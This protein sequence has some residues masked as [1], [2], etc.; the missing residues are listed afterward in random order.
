MN[1][2][3]PKSNSV[4]FFKS[5][6]RHHLGSRHQHRSPSWQE[7]TPRPRV[8]LLLLHDLSGGGGLLVRHDRLLSNGWHEAV[9]SWRTP[10]QRVH[11][12][13]SASQGIAS[14]D[15]VYLVAWWF[16]VNFSSG[17]EDV[18]QFVLEMFAA[19]YLDWDVF[20]VKRSISF[21]YSYN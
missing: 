8:Q 12:S 2:T 20:T 13:T 9:G 16:V 19:I 21:I 3:I 17:A 14:E 11:R 7:G 5:L 10:H 18:K 1:P 15:G 6:S 4:S